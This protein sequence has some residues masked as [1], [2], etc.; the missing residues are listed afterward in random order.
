MDSSRY[1]ACPTTGKLRSSACSRCSRSRAATA[2][3]A[4]KAAA[5]VTGRAWKS[6]FMPVT[7]PPVAGPG[8][9]PL[10]LRGAQPQALRYR[11][12]GSDST[13]GDKPIERGVPL[14][15][16]DLHATGQP[17]VTGLEALDEGLGVQP[18]PA[19]P[20]VLEP[21][22][23]QRNALGHALPGEGL[24][25]PV[26]CDLVEAASEAELL[27]VAL[28]HES[29]ATPVADVPVVDPGRDAV[30]SDPAREQLRVGVGPEELLGG[31]GEVAGDLDHRDVGDGLDGRL[32][33]RARSSG[34]HDAVPS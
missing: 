1:R 12:A 30:G 18:G 34:V 20:K 16:A 32:G 29:P 11:A 2:A 9:D 10:Q 24:H 7:M 3:T 31:R 5:A 19:V 4:E 14:V 28:V 26:A 25:D 33:V 15:D 13:I 23:L 22:R 17:A 8:Y 6:R 27:P 21:E